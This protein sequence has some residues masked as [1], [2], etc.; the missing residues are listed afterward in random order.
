MWMNGVVVEGW[1]G[2]VE[3][4]GSNPSEAFWKKSFT[5]SIIF[6]IILLYFIEIKTQYCSS[7]Q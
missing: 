4:V 7:E 5:F 1:D 6:D 2:N 3:D